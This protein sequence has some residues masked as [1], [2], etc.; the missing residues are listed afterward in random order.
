MYR[1]TMIK[2]GCAAIVLCVAGAGTAAADDGF[3]LEC[4][5]DEGEGS[6]TFFITDTKIS[7]VSEDKSSFK[8]MC[9]SD[10]LIR[11]ECSV[12][13]QMITSTEDGGLIVMT[14]S[15]NRITGVYLEEIKTDYSQGSVT[16]TCRKIDEP[17]PK[18][19]F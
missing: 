5:H 11:R 17:L 10:D 2:A 16:G 13:N 7:F 14:R 9:V 19:K 15:I 18:P 8:D 1:T 12:T 6:S 3:F 4:T